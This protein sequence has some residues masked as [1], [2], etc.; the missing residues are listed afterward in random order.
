MKGKGQISLEALIVLAAF[1]VILSQLVL[2]EK[3]KGE[4]GMQFF[5]KL[6]A[7]AEVE[8]CSI[9]IDSMSANPG[10]IAEN[11]GK[12]CYG[13]SNSKIYYKDQNREYSSQTL[14][15][16]IETIQRGKSFVTRIENET[17]Y[18]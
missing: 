4:Q 3:M 14:G 1:I 15:E 2:F 12:K 17:H 10:A 6:N 7:F 16:K 5:Q 11:S 8:K 9:I 13:K 18:S